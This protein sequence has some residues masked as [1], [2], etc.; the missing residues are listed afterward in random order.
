VI[1]RTQVLK[2]SAAGSK[3]TIRYHHTE[4]FSDRP[5]P[6]RHG[7][8]LGADPGCICVIATP[9]RGLSICATKQG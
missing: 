4:A 3:P 7:K 8:P 9:I 6:A 2:I 5:R 1:Y